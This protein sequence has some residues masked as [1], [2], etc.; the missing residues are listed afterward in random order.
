MR[1]LKVLPLIL[2]ALS[3][4]S[5]SNVLSTAPFGETPYVAKPEDWDGIWVA[6][7]MF[8]HMKVMDGPGGI[9]KAAWIEPYD[10]GFKM[11]SHDVWLR[12][13]GEWA[14]ASVKAEGDEGLYVWVHFKRDKEQIICIL[15]DPDEFK[16]LCAAGKIPCRDRGGDTIIDGLTSAH[17][18]AVT[19]K[20]LYDWPSP[21]VFTR[22]P[23]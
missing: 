11:E 8:I 9:I 22:L 7:E 13:T 21:L 23:R 10:K 15:P 17:T 3:L 6:R 18:A 19:S 20:G 12:K 1:N 16:T 14:F 4:C 5:C 2:L